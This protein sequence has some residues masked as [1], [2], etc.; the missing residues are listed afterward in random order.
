[1]TQAQTQTP[2]QNLDQF[3]AEVRARLANIDSGLKSLKTKADSDAKLF[4]L[5]VFAS[6]CAR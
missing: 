2:T 1:M 6:F 4:L 3:S 5:A